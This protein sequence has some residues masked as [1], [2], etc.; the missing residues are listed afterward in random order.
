M[1]DI[2]ISLCFGIA[3]FRGGL[4]LLEGGL[5]GLGHHGAL[6]R[7]EIASLVDLFEL[8]EGRGHVLILQGRHTVGRRLL[9]VLGDLSKA[10]LT[11]TGTCAG[12]I[13]RTSTT[14]C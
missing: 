7:R 12:S 5:H 13:G 11:A 1:E 10:W 6:L 9:R 14:Y 2:G 4:H 3:M 8:Q